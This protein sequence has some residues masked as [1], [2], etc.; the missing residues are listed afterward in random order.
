VQAISSLKNS[1]ERL[2]L[3]FVQEELDAYI[4]EMIPTNV[5]GSRTP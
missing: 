4:V 1:G 3:A 5:T 2:S